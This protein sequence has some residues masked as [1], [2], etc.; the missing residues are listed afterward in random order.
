MRM[1]RHR[2]H[3]LALAVCTT[4]I[5]TA[6]GDDSVV[7]GNSTL[8]TSATTTV[9]PATPVAAPSVVL[10]YAET[11]GCEMGGPNCWTFTLWSDGKVEA[12]RTRVGGP[13]EA[14]GSIEPD[15]VAQWLASVQSL[16]VDALTKEVGPGSCAG[17][18]D[19]IDKVA[20]IQLSD[21]RV[22][23]DSQA[24]FFDP[25]NPTFAALDSFVTEVRMSVGELPM[26]IGG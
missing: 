10:T 7:S 23:L 17:C 26:H 14:T 20:T 3:L 22:V 15:H 24:M 2:S 12:T 1:T 5:V 13:A 25:A 18:L 16:D 4:F 11:G 21:R 8:D 9:V 6:C 19:G